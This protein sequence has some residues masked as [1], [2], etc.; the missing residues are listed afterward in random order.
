MEKNID[1]INKQEVTGLHPKFYSCQSLGAALTLAGCLD[2]EA[3]S[4][5]EA[6]KFYITGKTESRQGPVKVQKAEQA[7]NLEGELELC[8]CI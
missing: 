1:Q 2:K 7:M 3:K 8:F 4:G 6:M 5:G